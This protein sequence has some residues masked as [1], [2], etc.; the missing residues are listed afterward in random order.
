MAAALFHIATTLR[1]ERPYV[2]HGIHNVMLA[3]SR[4]TLGPH[5]LFL[6]K[7]RDARIFTEASIEL[8]WKSGV[9]WDTILPRSSSI[10]Y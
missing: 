8:P 5:D 6:D 4:H 10:V 3:R 7:L 9:S 1:T 2:L